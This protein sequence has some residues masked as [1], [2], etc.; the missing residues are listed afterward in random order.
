MPFSNLAL[1]DRL[2]RV[3]LGVAAVSLGWTLELHEVLGL[4]LRILGWVPLVTG[5]LG[6]SPLYSLLNISTRRSG[7][8]SDP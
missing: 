8:R 3:A 5:L 7:A 4:A 1:W 6:W 2:L